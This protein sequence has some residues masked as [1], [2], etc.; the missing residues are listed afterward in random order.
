VPSAWLALGILL[1]LDVAMFIDVFFDA[2]RVLSAVGNDIGLQFLSWRQFGFAELAAGRIPLWNPY[3]YAGAPYLGGFQAALFYPLNLVHLVFPV[4]TAINLVIGI[5]IWM[6][7]AL[8]YAWART[9]GVH[10]AAALVSGALLMFSAPWMLRVYGGHV[11]ALSTLTWAPLVMLGVDRLFTPGWLL[12]SLG[13]AVVVAL[14]ILA[15]H[16]QCALYCAVGGAAYA[17][18]RLWA[19]PA[20]RTVI[21][22]L[23]VM[24][25]GAVALAAIQ[26]LP[27]L[28]AAGESVRAGRTPY[29]FARM[30]SL[31]PENLITFVV[32]GFFG[33]LAHIPYWGRTYLWESSVFFGVAGFVLA[34]YGAMRGDAA[35]RRDLLTA[36]AVLGI[37]ALGSH[38]P[39]FTV[40]Y[41]L[42]LFAQFRGTCKFAAPMVMCG[43]LL[44][45]AGLDRLIRGAVPGVRFLRAT[46]FGAFVLVLTGAL[47]FA[48]GAW[49]MPAWLI[50]AARAVEATKESY[51]P[52]DA[53]VS[54]VFMNDA[55]RFAG[56][57]C[58]AAGA[59]AVVLTGLLW[60]L[61][62]RRWPLYG[63]AALA[64]LEVFGHARA[65]RAT[66]RASELVPADLQQFFA[67]RA[68]DGRVLNLDNPNLALML[69]ERDVWGLDP[70][71]PK[72]YAEFM[73]M[74]QGIP[75]D[76]ATQS[77]GIES[78]NPL[79]RMLRLEY[80]LDRST[81]RLRVADEPHPMGRVALLYD[82]RLATGRDDVFR[83]LGASDF[84]PAARV[85]LEAPPGIRPE[86][87]AFDETPN[88]SVVDE[89]TDR[90]TI[91]ATLS[92]PAVL[93]LTD[94][95]SRDWRAVAH[96][97]SAQPSYSV[98]PANYILIAVPLAAGRHDFTLEYAPPSYALGQVITGVSLAGLVIVVPVLRRRRS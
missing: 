21:A 98:M 50:A 45:G 77:F 23:A 32:P 39:A 19:G 5:H 44:A 28:A 40:L 79:Y 84:D 38:T 20:R 27:G 53:Y 31:P 22:G 65:S 4:A 17:A 75:P 13:G 26:V 3:V 9:R 96:E 34:L 88:V 46:A 41:Q 14:Q 86:R 63:I 91:T 29:V 37:L 6:S 68:G 67:K 12:A 61:S 82:W 56:V 95:Y 60:G 69:R 97:G 49:S 51:L 87:P 58:L 48:A 18:P 76:E 36:A 71:L 66:F 72:R 64:V 24:Y 94:G 92:R 73:A 57:A 15:G 74:T 30:F 11:A 42:P 70:A 7:G 62:R 80:V 85:I 33:D 59:T 78:G 55:I 8:M 16:P 54:D 47:L 1:A 81:G 52:A 93:L 90:V 25:V 43:T 89:S 35:L 83:Q 10:P 2:D